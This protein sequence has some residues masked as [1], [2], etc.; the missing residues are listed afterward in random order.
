MQQM[1]ERFFEA[2]KLATELHANQPRKGRDVPYLSHLLRVAGMVL[3]Y[4]A[5]EDTVIAAL[6][7]DAIEDQGGLKTSTLIRERFG[8]RVQKFVLDCSDSFESLGKPKRPWRERKE[9]Y[10]AHIETMDPESR[11][12]VACDKLDNLRCTLA[13]YRNQGENFW[14]LFAGD[15][16]GTLWYY[17]EVLKAIRKAGDCPVLR[18]IEETLEMLEKAVSST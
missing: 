2:V 18:E 10:I 14:E 8:A 5:D 9:S 11:L 1:T 16:D 12:I 15:R 3:G 13:D 6:L 7:H 4:G 17:R